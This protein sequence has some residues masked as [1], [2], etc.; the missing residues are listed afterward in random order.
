MEMP[1]IGKYFNPTQLF[2]WIKGHRSGVC[3]LLPYMAVIDLHSRE[4]IDSVASD[5]I[6]RLF[7][8]PSASAFT[9]V[10]VTYNLRFFGI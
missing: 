2:D 4:I 1:R 3:V 10:H 5:R 8:C 9:T 6:V 7:V